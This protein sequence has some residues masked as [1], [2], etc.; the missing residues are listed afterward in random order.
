MERNPTEHLH[1]EKDLQ[2]YEDFLTYAG[3][4]NVKKG[5][6]LTPRHITSLFTKL[7]DI[8]DDGSIDFKDNK[9]KTIQI[10]FSENELRGERIPIIHEE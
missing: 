9:E 1:N 2:F 4:S 3:V 6:V 7:V 5:I 8:K 10:T